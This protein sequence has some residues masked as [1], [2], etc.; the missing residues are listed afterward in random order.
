MFSFLVGIVLVELSLQAYGLYLEYRRNILLPELEGKVRILAIGEST[1]DPLFIPGVDAW[2]KRLEDQLNAQYAP[3]KFAVVNKGR[4]GASTT[5]LV[6]SLPEQ[7]EQFK[8]HLVIVM[9]GLNDGFRYF[10]DNEAA[11]YARL[12]LLRVIRNFIMRRTYPD[13]ETGKKSWVLANEIKEP[14][15]IPPLLSEMMK[16]DPMDEALI[17]RIISTRYLRISEDQ[18]GEDRRKTERLAFQLAKE[19]LE[20]N[21]N[22]K[23]ALLNLINSSK[24]QDQLRME[25]RAIMTRIIQ[26]GFPPSWDHIA[27]FNLIKD[28]DE[29]KFLQL[30]AEKGVKKLGTDPVHITRENFHQLAKLVRSSGSKL[31]VMAYPTTKI[32]VF[33]NIFTNHVFERWSLRLNMEIPVPPATVPDEFSDIIFIENRN[34]PSNFNRNFYVDI[35]VQS[36]VVQ[37]GFGHTTQKGHDLI[38]K[39]AFD[40]LS[41]KWVPEL[42]ST[43]R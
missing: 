14:G 27:F 6:K 39:N 37:V 12:K 24:H 40:V 15:N 10:F 41:K 5:V 9:M 16:K 1:T 13:P 30:L 43:F 29:K 31:A 28:K 7:L 8:P 3:L 36:P 4:A 22:D 19:S 23:E 25:S 34:F 17:K 21:P 32:D 26:S 20:I 35:M 42:Q 11:W 38:A 2:P 18:Q 33:K